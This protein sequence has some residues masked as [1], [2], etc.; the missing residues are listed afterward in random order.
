MDR[1]Y[2]QVI[3]RQAVTTAID[4]LSFKPASGKPCVVLDA[5]DT[6]HTD[7]GDAQA[8]GLVAHLVRG[9]TTDPAGGA[10]N[11][12][13]V[14][15]PSIVPAFSG[16][17]RQ[18]DTTLASAGTTTVHGNK[19]YN[20]QTGYEERRVPEGFLYVAAG[21]WLCLRSP[22]APA[23]SLTRSAGIIFHEEG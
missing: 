2:E 11:T 14:I 8:E 5:W 13:G 6:Q 23:D 16:T 1:M 22:V 20:V 15:N 19:G 3:D 12:P 4:L 17:A 7:Y 10:T 9:H 21:I 18:L